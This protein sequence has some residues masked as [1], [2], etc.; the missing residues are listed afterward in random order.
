VTKEEDKDDQPERA[1][2]PLP[3]SHRS[4]SRPPLS[5]QA[6]AP[7]WSARARRQR[8]QSQRT[9]F[10]AETIDSVR[11]RCPE[12]VRRV[13]EAL[14]GL[15]MAHDLRAAPAHNIADKRTPTD[16]EGNI[17]ARDVFGLDRPQGVV[18]QFAHR[19]GF[20]DYFRLPV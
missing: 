19:A 1:M 17:L 4:W 6:I 12:D 20:A 8:G 10:S 9:A 14:H 11:I 7:T 5:R 2:P 16:A 18:A 15:A 3:R 13:A